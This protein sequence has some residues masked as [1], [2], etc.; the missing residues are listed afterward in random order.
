MD[1]FGATLRGKRGE[2]SLTELAKK[3]GLSVSYLCDVEKGRCAPSFP[4]VIR[5]IKALEIK[6]FEGFFMEAV[7]DRKEI[8]IPLKGS[9]LFKKRLLALAFS[10][11]KIQEEGVFAIQYDR[12]FKI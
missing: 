3:T 1:M 6:P 2:M 4:V 9:D 7:G 12:L 5:L 11:P 10:L 8:R